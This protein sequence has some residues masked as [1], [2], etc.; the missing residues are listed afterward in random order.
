MDER[1]KVYRI[2][3]TTDDDCDGKPDSVY[4]LARNFWDASRFSN[5]ETKSIEL[6]AEVQNACEFKQIDLVASN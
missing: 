6:L 5:S 1:L 4:V 2:Q 3:K